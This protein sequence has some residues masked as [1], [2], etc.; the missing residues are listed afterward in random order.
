MTFSPVKKKGFSLFCVF[1]RVALLRSS[2]EFKET[3]A[4][5]YE[6][7]KGCEIVKIERIQNKQL[8]DAFQL[9]VCV[10]HVYGLT[11]SG[12][13]AYISLPDEVAIVLPI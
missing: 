7:M 9:Y 11:P 3:E 10:L 13:S 12:S 5:F 6:T 4:L 2:K 1:Q 8:W